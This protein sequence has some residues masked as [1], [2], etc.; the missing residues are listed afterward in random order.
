MKQ[1]SVASAVTNSLNS[2]LFL[3]RP[4]FQIGFLFGI[5][6]SILALDGGIYE[7]VSFV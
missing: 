1:N 7:V 3:L 5:V 4:W 2:I 6:F